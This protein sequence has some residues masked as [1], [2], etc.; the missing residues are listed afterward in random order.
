MTF[1]LAVGDIQLGG[2][3]HMRI[4][5]PSGTVDVPDVDPQPPLPDEMLGL[6]LETLRMTP[7]N[8]MRYPPAEGGS[9]WYIWGG[10]TMSQAASFFSPIQVRYIG[11]YI[12]NVQPLLDLPPGF[13]FSIAKSSPPKVWFDV[14]L[15][16]V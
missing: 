8:G 7:L 11:D 5:I 12:R 16:D 15:L 4:S 1:S 3:R 10:E 14:S 13:R 6:A 2:G 9:G